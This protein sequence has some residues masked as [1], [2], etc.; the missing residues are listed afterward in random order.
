[1]SNTDDDLRLND[2]S[3]IRLEKS[4]TKSGSS[5]VTDTNM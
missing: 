4:E 3:Q 2:F 1:M 5:I